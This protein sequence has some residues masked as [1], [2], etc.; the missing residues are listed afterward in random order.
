MAKPVQIPAPPD[1]KFGILEFEPVIERT[2]IMV[3]MNNNTPAIT[4][5]IVA[6]KPAL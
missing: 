5:I 2:C 3:A 6:T 4:N 1:T